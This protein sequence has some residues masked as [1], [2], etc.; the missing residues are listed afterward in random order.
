M[1]FTPTLLAIMVSATCLSANANSITASQTKTQVSYE[2][3]ADAAVWVSPNNANEDLLISTLEGDGL[4]VFDRTGRILL[5]DASQEVLGADIRYGLKDDKNSLDV[6]AVG[7]PEEEAFAFYRIDP[8]ATPILQAVGRIDT[9]IAPE[10]V[11]LYKNVTTGE[12]TVTG[13]SDDGQIVQYKIRNRAGQIVSAVVDKQ[14][15]PIAVRETQVG[16][17]LS[18]CVADDETGTLYVAEQNVGIWAYG[19]DAENVKDRRLV[20]VAQP[21]GH[22]EEIESMDMLYQADGKGYLLIADEGAG[23][24]MYDRDAEQALQASFDVEGVEEAKIIT[25]SPSGLWIGNTEADEPVY[26]FLPLSELQ[27]QLKG[28]DLNEVQSHRQLSLEGVKLVAATGETQEVSEDG[29]AADD[30]AFWLNPVD[31]SQSLIIATNKKGGLM[32]YDLQ[33]REVQFLEEGEPNNVDIRT[34]TDWDGS[35]FALATASNRDLN[36]LALYKIQAGK[37]PI[38]PLKAIGK[39]RHEEAAEFVSGVDEVYGLCMYKAKSGQ[40]YAF[41]NGK[42]GVIEQWRLTATKAGIEGEVVRRLQVDSQ[43]E[44]CVADDATGIL[45][46]GEEDVAIWTFQADE[47]ASTKAS[48]FAA[49]DGKHLVDDIE[50]L[51]LYQNGKENY[52]IASSQGNNTYAIYDLDNDNRYLASFAIIGDDEKG[53]D[54]SSDTDGIHAVTANLGEDYP[55]GLFLAQ[56]W[57]NLDAEYRA[58][59]QNFKIVDWRNIEQAL[60]D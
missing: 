2:D 18:A 6:L 47:N 8:Q 34:I 54:G 35:E 41:M 17:E 24:L 38:Q 5:T 26:E 25:A 37:E 32:A 50:G 11:C 20:D 43:P 15:K 55:H 1:K 22:L 40:V 3:I 52:L 9:H 27:R 45:Y 4:A 39:Q 51:T 33:G 48:L 7:L 56:D 14:G 46:V 59:K 42:N 19:A 10:A 49:V 23:F 36:T 31:A 30:P 29:D 28:L 16:G 58:Q 53:V 60:R 57:Y 44:G 21:L 12:T 13:L